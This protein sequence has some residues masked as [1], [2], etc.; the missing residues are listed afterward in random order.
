MGGE[1]GEKFLLDDEFALVISSSPT[2]LD[3]RLELP[4]P[5]AFD[6]GARY[7]WLEDGLVDLEGGGGVRLAP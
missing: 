1:D 5:S 6:G 7:T 3:R 2:D 4:L